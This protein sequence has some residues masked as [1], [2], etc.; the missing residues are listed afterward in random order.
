MVDEL[1][2]RYTALEA[3]ALRRAALTRSN[4]HA[5]EAARP[6]V[7][8]T[9][10]DPGSYVLVSVDSL[11]KKPSSFTKLSPKWMG[12]YIAIGLE[13]A[14]TLRVSQLGSDTTEV[15][16]VKH[17]RPYLPLQD[18]DATM[19]E[20]L[21]RAD[22]SLAGKYVVEKLLEIRL[23]P[24][25]SDYQVHV[26]WLGYDE[27][28]WVPLTRLGADISTMLREFVESSACTLRAATKK[29]VLRRLDASVKDRVKRQESGRVSHMRRTP[30]V[31]PPVG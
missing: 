28:T 24:G 16:H 31:L 6:H 18:D 8:E 7:K 5:A 27:T 2:A 11:P 25:G 10:F 12:P 13:N 9:S 26:Q 21:R 29:A 19:R 22:A 23:G 15:V 17:V 1:R 30:R 14:N 3:A 20:L 4:A